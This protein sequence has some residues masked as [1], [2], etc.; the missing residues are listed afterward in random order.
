MNLGQFLPIYRSLRLLLLVK[1]NNL[2]LLV[3]LS[4][5]VLLLPVSI[6]RFRLLPDGV[7]ERVFLFVYLEVSLFQLY[8][9]FDNVVRPWINFCHKTQTPYS[10]GRVVLKN[11]HNLT[12]LA[13]LVVC[14]FDWSLD[15]GKYS[16]MSLLP[17]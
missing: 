11:P 8:V 9:N 14:H 3:S 10:S 6:N 15:V 16:F 7:A 13:A 17:N 2:H 4:P 5:R 12:T 1:Q